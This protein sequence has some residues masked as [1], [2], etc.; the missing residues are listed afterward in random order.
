MWV[1]GLFLIFFVFEFVLT[2]GWDLD[3]FVWDG[4]YC[5]QT[6]QGLGYYMLQIAA[7]VLSGAG[8]CCLALYGVSD[9]E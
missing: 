9:L 2:G 7:S 1:W 6:R 5:G 4:L 8:Y 3:W